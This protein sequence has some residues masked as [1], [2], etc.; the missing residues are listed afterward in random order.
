MWRIFASII[1]G[2]AV[3]G[4]SRDFMGVVASWERERRWTE[5]FRFLYAFL[6]DRDVCHFDMKVLGSVW[7]HDLEFRYLVIVEIWIVKL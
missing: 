4:R 5:V 3:S 1:S 2:G 7:E 6:L